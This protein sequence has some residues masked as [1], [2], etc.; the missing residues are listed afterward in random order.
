MK[1]SLKAMI[2]V[3]LVLILAMSFAAC[4]K[5]GASSGQIE[6]NVLNYF[7]MTVANAADEVTSV[8]EAFE[9]ANPDIKL[10]REDLFN[11][12]F[13]N[14][15]ESYAAAGQLP[16]VL[17]AWPS[18]RS[19][20]LH[21][22][23]LLKDLGP[24]VQRDGLASQYIPLAMDPAQQASNY[25]GILTQGITAT[26]AFFVNMEVL[27]DCG[28]QPAK[29]Y[30]EMKAQVPVLRAKGYE[31]ILMANQDTW[32]M[33]S[34]LFSLIA[35]RFCGEGWEE[36]ILS[37]QAKFTDPDF[38]AAL[39]FVKAMY[40]DGVL[41]RTTLTTGYGDVVG[42]F[43]TNKGAYYIDGDW[44]VGAFITDQSTGQ[45]L[46]TP[47]RQRD[48]QITVFP[49]I[50]GVKFNKSNSAV[51]GT[52]WGM[53]AAI[54]SGSPKEEAAWKLI[55]W[56]AGNEVL[57]WRVRTGGVPTPS[58]TDI[59]FASLNLEPMQVAIANLGKE[60]DKATVVIDGA[61]DGSVYE[62]INDGLQAIGMGI[63]T[64]QQVASIAQAALEAWKAS[65]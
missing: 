35:G 12:P 57:T 8:W 27:R 24:L 64:P 5:S 53:S 47:A 26:N 21:T 52:G 65:R 42:L 13:H 36:K 22:Q 50:E 10:I 30:A 25:L 16:D 63:Q 61:F 48:I 41:N 14:K 11:E 40:D 17:Y 55:K 19:T 56:L 4:K 6:L 34:C 9:K 2:S 43:A 29:T 49:D 3:T 31:T 32:V 60:Y 33:Q 38:V 1:R 37:G 23:R 58:R 62:P 45:A 28:L 18:G 59:N 54:P 7:D 44:R 46:I 20:T 15:T 51:L 39:N